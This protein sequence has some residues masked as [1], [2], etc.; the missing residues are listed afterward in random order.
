VTVEGRR[1]RLG[2][3]GSTLVEVIASLVIVAMISLMLLEGVGAGRRVWER[4][5]SRQASGDAIEGA[6]SALRDRIEQSFPA[7]LDLITPP[8][9]DFE[10]RDDAVFFLSNPP[11]SVRPAPLRRYR[12]LLDTDGN[13]IL[14]SVSDA[15]PPK[16]AA[17][18]I[19]RLLT[20]VRQ[21]K[22]DYFGAADGD[23]RR[24]TRV[25]QNQPVLPDVVRVRVAFGPGDARVWPD[26]MIHPRTT[27][28]AGCLLDPQTH[29]CRGRV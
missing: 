12:L 21:L 15:A 28:D 23:S 1:I 13:L 18:Q 2:E 7:T 16:S 26:L 19:Q 8:A 29:R 20:G 17:V 22:I 4:I 14:S 3:S 11:Q 25:W 9:V 6:Q 10:G 5:D 24:W 27:V